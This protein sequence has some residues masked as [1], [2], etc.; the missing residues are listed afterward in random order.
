M[1]KP[2]GQNLTSSTSLSHPPSALDS[3]LSVSTSIPTKSRTFLSEMHTLMANRPSNYK[4]IIL[5][6]TL[7][8]I[9]TNT[10]GYPYLT[11]TTQGTP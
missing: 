1:P 6:Y 7:S 8:I 4:L 5:Q 2:G 3:S 10:T 9:I 11:P